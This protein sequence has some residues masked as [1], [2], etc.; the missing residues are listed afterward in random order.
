MVYV[1]MCMYVCMRACV[2]VRVYVCMHVCVRVYVCMCMYVCVF[3]YVCMYA[4]MY[5][6]M[7]VYL[8]CPMRTAEVPPRHIYWIALSITY[9]TAVVRETH[10]RRL[11]GQCAEGILEVRGRKLQ[12]SDFYSVHSWTH[13]IGI[14]RSRSIRCTIEDVHGKKL[15]FDNSKEKTVRKT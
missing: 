3:M 8:I 12:D 11:M 6:C 14:T 10:R 2:C 15:T 9:Q 5:D 1:C 4:C 7:H 13:P